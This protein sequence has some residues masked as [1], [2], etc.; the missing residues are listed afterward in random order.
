M[1]GGD[2][3]GQG[4]VG[5]GGEEDGTP[6]GLLVEEKLEQGLVIGKVG[7]V[8]G[9]GGG[10]VLFE[11]GFALGEPGRKLEQGA[12]ILPGE[13]EN[14]VDEGVGLDKG[15]VEIDAKGG[16]GGGRHEGW[17]DC[18]LDAGL[19]AV[20]DAGLG[21]ITRWSKIAALRARSNDP[22]HVPLLSFHVLDG[23]LTPF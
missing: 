17:S 5:C 3:F 22:F 15:S 13:G 10:D 1:V 23:G 18:C 11:R 4:G 6:G 21:Q 12:R 20:L 8:K 19:D 2:A 16:L 14:R 7:H 9:D